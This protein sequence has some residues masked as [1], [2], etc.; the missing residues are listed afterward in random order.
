MNARDI[1]QRAL[2]G[3]DWLVSLQAPDGAWNGLET[4]MVDGF[5]KS[6]WALT[7]TGRLPQAHRS[8]DYCAR[9]FLTADGDFLPREHPWHQGVHYIYANSYF[10][11]GAMAAGRYE[12]ARPATRFVLT[13]Q[14]A[15]CGGI[16]SRRVST[17]SVRSYDTMSA[18]A[19]G[20]ALLAAGERT[21]AQQIGEFLGRMVDAQPEANRRFYTTMRADGKLL[22]DFSADDVFASVIDATEPDQ[23]WYAVGLPLAFL[24]QLH[25]ASGET[26]WASLADW[27]FGFQE[28]CVNPWDGGSSGK[29]GWAT[30]MMYRRTGDPSYRDIALRVARYITERQDDDGGWAGVVGGDGLTNAAM[31][32]SAEYTLWCALIAANLLSR[33][34]V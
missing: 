21:A 19:A 25:D 9:H 2:S 33:D 1:W 20:M 24:I 10:V 14:D 4:P 17:T 3:A 5:Y 6:S 31:D 23:C 22:L 7:L 13:Q 30:A 29:A 28:Q 16:S 11:V 15:T 12:I 34:G 32:V 26:R 27:Y 18:G 8:L